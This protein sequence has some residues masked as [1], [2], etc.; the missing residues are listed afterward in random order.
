MGERDGKNDA[1][2]V[3]ANKQNVMLAE[4]AKVLGYGRE[5]GYEEIARC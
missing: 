1:V 5:I 4:M 2:I 3:W